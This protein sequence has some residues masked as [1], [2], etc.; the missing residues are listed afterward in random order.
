MR[1]RISEIDL[2]TI[3]G[4]AIM[5]TDSGRKSIPDYYGENVFGIN[6]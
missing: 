5:T 4:D 3:K 6:V 2:S 1:T